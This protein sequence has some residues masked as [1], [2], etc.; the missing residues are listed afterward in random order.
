MTEATPAVTLTA[1]EGPSGAP[2]QGTIPPV[3]SPF[4]WKSRSRGAESLNVVTVAP[5]PV[6]L[7]RARRRN[8]RVAGDK[9]VTDA[10]PAFTMTLSPR[11]TA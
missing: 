5:G 10:V 6:S 8:G 7:L 1:L 9:K 2:P 11:T 4:G 3:M